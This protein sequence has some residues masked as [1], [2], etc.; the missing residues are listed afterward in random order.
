MRGRP[1]HD[2]TASRADAAQWPLFLPV[3]ADQADQARKV[4]TMAAARATA[5]Q[6]ARSVRLPVVIDRVS[7]IKDAATVGDRAD[8]PSTHAQPGGN[9]PLRQLTF[10]EQ[11][12]DLFNHGTREHVA[13]LRLGK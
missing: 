7:I 5:G 13:E 6:R 8:R 3:F 1:I 2:I 4:Y 10:V 11:S 12:I 9:L